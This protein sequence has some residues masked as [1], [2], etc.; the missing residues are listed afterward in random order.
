[1]SYPRNASRED[2]EAAYRDERRVR[3][4]LPRTVSLTDDMRLR[5]LAADMLWHRRRDVLATQ[6]LHFVLDG[7]ADPCECFHAVKAL[8]RRLP[9]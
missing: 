8:R 7:F 3:R 6:Q 2:F 4:A 9:R 5:W 1:M